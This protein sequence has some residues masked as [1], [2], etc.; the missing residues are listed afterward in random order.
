LIKARPSLA[1]A[2]IGLIVAGET[3][4]LEPVLAVVLATYADIDP[5]GAVTRAR[6]LLAATNPTVTRAVAHSAGWNRGHRALAAGERELLLD[7][8]AHPDAVVR[9][10]S[11][12]AAQ[13]MAETDPAAACELLAAVEFSDGPRLADEV[14]MCFG[15]PFGL[16]WEMLTPP[17]VSAMRLRLVGL[18]DF[19]EHH[20]VMSFLAER[21]AAD[22]D[23]VIELLQ[24]RVTHAEGLEALGDYRPMPYT[25]DEPLRVRE[26]RDFVAHLRRLHAWIAAEPDSPI[27]QEMGAKIFAEVAGPFDETVLA[28]FGDA[29]SSSNAADFRAVTAILG[30][31]PQNLIWDFPQFVQGALQAQTSGTRVK[32]AVEVGGVLRLF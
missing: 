4:A 5:D 31:A 9:Q 2:F 24:D 29:L 21:S 28:V 7:F 18:P 26:N 25:W 30:K 27:R 8:A 32:I 13:Q 20:A 3:P 15:K 6:K 17:Q 14:F 11:A 19:G 22:P 23:W 10:A 16:S 12:M 1:S